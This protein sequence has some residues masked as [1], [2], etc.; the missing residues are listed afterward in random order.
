VIALYGG[1]LPVIPLFAVVRAVHDRPV[2][3]LT[4]AAET[5]CFALF[6]YSFFTLL[7]PTFVN[8]PNL[9]DARL[10]ERERERRDFVVLRAFRTLGM[11]LC[12]APLWVM[13]AT[14]QRGWPWLRNP[15]LLAFAAW[16]IVILAMTLPSAMLAWSEPDSLA[17]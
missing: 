17:G 5:V 2:M 13:A 10:D 9:D 14:A 6:C 15:D 1:W 12:I 3:I 8:A 4:L 7:Q 16:S 11:L